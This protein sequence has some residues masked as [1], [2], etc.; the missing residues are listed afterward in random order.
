MTQRIARLSCESMWLW[1][2][3]EFLASLL[4]RPW[5]K[6]V[7]GA[8]WILGAVDLVLG[9]F[10]SKHVQERSPRFFEFLPDLDPFTWASIALFA[11]L[12][13]LTEGAYRRVRAAEQ[14]GVNRPSEATNSPQIP[15]V[16]SQNSSA[17]SDELIA[18]VEA[19][20]QAASCQTYRW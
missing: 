17:T 11:L 6:L 16:C 12:V 8:V 15:L 10:I 7:N 3:I 13:T 20:G 18:A 1:A 14:S 19:V 2:R 4:W 9:Q 5:S